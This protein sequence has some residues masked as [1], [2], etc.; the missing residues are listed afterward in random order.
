MTTP[1]PYF[2]RDGL[3]IHRGDCLQVMPQLEASSVSTIVTDPPYGLEFMGKAWDHGVPGAE[4]WREALR[5]VKPG[6]VLLA[7]G[8]TRTFHRLAVALEDAGWQIRDCLSWL[9]GCGFPKS[10]DLSK[11]VDKVEPRLDLF[12]TFATHYEERRRAAGLTHAAVC[13]LGGFH[14]E[15]NHGGASVNWSKGYGVPTRAQWDVLAPALELSLEFLPLI[16]RE[17]AL[18][19]KVAERRGREL[20]YRPGSGELGREAV[21]DVTAPGSEHGHV[22]DGY[23]TALKPAWE[24]ILLAMKPTEGTFAQNAIA[25]GV[26]GLNLGECRIPTT[27]SERDWMAATARPKAETT[28]FGGMPKPP[29]F[30]PNEGGRHPA[31]LL[32]DE[33]SAEALDDQAGE[34]P[35]GALSPE[36]QARG[37]FAGARSCYGTAQRGGERTF[38]QSTGGASRFFYTSKAGRLDRSGGGFAENTHP[39][40]K[41]ADLMRYLVRL[42]TMPEGTVVL[43]PFMGSGSTLVAARDE[44]VQAIGIEL[45]EAYCEVAADRLSQGAFMF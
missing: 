32:L 43:D 39:T 7:F 15:K 12:D 34:R 24:P 37:G 4:F 10:L 30:T 26:A 27:P 38:E 16:D 41:P 2:E 9:Y 36:A 22:W 18:R 33:I 11:A 31:N 35:S 45:E 20:D 23:G 21:I 19:V 3:T 1:A 42:V 13:S 17:E 14:G 28:G 44:H 29:G 8:G 40:V 5:V 6:G 25:H